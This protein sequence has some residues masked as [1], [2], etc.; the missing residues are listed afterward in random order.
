[1]KNETVLLKDETVL[2]QKHSFNVKVL[3]ILCL[4]LLSSVLTVTFSTSVKGV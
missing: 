3:G 4:L 2:L 1:M